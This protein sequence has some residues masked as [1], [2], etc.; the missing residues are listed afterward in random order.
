[1]E[2]EGP[3]LRITS[4]NVTKSTVSS[5]NEPLSFL[6]NFRKLES[7]FLGKV[8]LFNQPFHKFFHNNFKILQI[9]DEHKVHWYLTI[10]YL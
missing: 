1:M 10:S 5:G 8:Q 6:N 9:F 3:T 4:G 2:G 7:A